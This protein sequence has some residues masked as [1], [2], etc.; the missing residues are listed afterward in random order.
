MYANR[1]VL[2]KFNLKFPFVLL[3]VFHGSIWWGVEVT[4]KNYVGISENRESYRTH[5]YVIK[6]H[7]FLWFNYDGVY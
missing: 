2:L 6:S 4:L 5:W 3:I 1:A 7:N